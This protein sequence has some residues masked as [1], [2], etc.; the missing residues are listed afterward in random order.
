MLYYFYKIEIENN[1]YIGMTKNYDKRIAHH[2]GCVKKN[3]K[4]K[5]YDFINENGGWDYVTYCIVDECECETIMIARQHEQKLINEYNSQLNAISSFATEE[6]KKQ[7]KEI[8]RKQW[9]QTESGKEKHNNWIKNNHDRVLLS[10]QKYQN[11]N[12]EKLLQKNRAYQESNRELINERNRLC[13]ER[14]KAQKQ[15]EAQCII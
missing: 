6:E 7:R 2:R 3:K 1:T 13:R 8:Y 5:L 4:L 12:K 10:K 9:I 15:I 11:N 14:K